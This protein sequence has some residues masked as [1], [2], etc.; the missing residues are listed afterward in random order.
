[1]GLNVTLASYAGSMDFGFVGNGVALPHLSELA[2]F[3]REA[4]DELKAA[5]AKRVLPD[6]AAAG[7]AAGKTAKK[8]AKKAPRKAPKAAAKSAPQAATEARRAPKRA[9]QR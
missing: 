8:P 4:F 3:T 9:A 1:M 2:R 6:A 5:A 7:D